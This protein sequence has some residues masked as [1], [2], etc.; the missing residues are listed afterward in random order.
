MLLAVRVVLANAEFVDI[1]ESSKNT[2]IVFLVLFFS[3][4]IS[5]VFFGSFV[6]FDH[7]QINKVYLGV[8]FGSKGHVQMPPNNLIKQPKQAFD[9]LDLNRVKTIFKLGTKVNNSKLWSF[10]SFLQKTLLHSVP[11]LL[12]DIILNMTDS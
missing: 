10:P 1:V 3:F 4:F 9:Q 11:W 6:L 2:I 5:F 7:V 8:T 12:S